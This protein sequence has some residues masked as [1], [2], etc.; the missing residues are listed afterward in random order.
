[1]TIASRMS[2]V[3]EKLEGSVTFEAQSE[4]HGGRASHTQAHVAE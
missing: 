1:M 2:E 4:W 3:C